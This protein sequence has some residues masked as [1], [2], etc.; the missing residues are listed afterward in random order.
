MTDNECGQC[1][2]IFASCRPSFRLSATSS[3]SG[4]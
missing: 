1:V 3:P 4:R 2:V